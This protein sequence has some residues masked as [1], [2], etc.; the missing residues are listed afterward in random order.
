MAVFF[1]TRYMAFLYGIVFLS[2]QLGSFTAVW[3]GGWLYSNTG[4]YDSIWFA[5]IVL[6]LAAGALHWPIEERCQ[7]ERLRPVEVR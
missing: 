3:L 2:H 1:G 4:N 7:V 6:A 5:G